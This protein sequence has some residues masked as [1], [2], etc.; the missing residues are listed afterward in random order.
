MT[1]FNDRA[2]IKL[3]MFAESE[4]KQNEQSTNIVMTINQA[5]I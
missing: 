2:C 4:K 5:G 1:L 3:M